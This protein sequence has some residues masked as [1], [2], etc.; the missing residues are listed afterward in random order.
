MKLYSI[1]DLCEILGITS[2]TLNVYL[3][4]AEFGHLK[5]IRINKYKY[6]TNITI[7]DIKT[8]KKLINRKANKKWKK[9]VKIQESNI[10]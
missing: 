5:N 1:A 6:F 4:R 10:S 9:K 8:L 3:N 7:N 2:Q